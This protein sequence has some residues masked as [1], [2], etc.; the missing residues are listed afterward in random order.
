MRSTYS[1]FLFVAM[2]RGA[3]P[4]PEARQV[5]DPRAI[6]SRVNPSAGP[7]EIEDLYYTR[8][9][10]AASWSPDGKE[11]VFAT[12]LAGR[13]NLW[14]VAAGGG[15]PVQLMQSDD[16]QLHPVWSPDG[17]WIL[18]QQDFGGGEYFDLFL[19][20]SS[21]G[22]AI[23]LTNSPD[24]SETG[25]LWSPDG[26]SIAFFSK[27]RKGSSTDI[28][29]MDVV[30]RK[31]SQLTHEN[32][33]E[34]SWSVAAW[35]ADGRSVIANRR[36]V[37]ATDC[38]VYRVDFAS[39]Q[40]DELTPHSGQSVIAA[41]AVSPDG[42]TVLVSSS[43]KGGVSK[44]ALLNVAAKKLDWV[45]D[46]KWP[47]FPGSFSPL[48]DRFTYAVNEDGRTDLYI[49][50]R[51]TLKASHIDFLHGVSTF[52]GVTGTFSPSGQQLL[53]SHTESARP[54]DL[55]VHGIK[56][57][58]SRQLTVSALGS[59]DPSR[60]P[61]AQLIHYRSF[62][63]TLISAFLWVPHNLKR[64]GAAPAVL[65]PHGGPAGQVRDTFNQTA[66]ALA[67]RGYICIAPNV[68]GSSGYGE[69]FEHMNHKDL[70]GGDLQDEVY[71][72]RFVIDTGYA[73]PARI[74][75]AG[76]SYGGYMTLMAVAKTPDLWA[77]GVDSYGI[78]SW[79]TM[80]QHS[81]PALQAYQRSLL[82][83]PVADRKVYEDDSPITFM[84]NVKA[85]L[86]VLHGD[87]DI[88]VPKEEAQQVVD[89]LEKQHNVVAAHYYPA[90]GHGFAKRENQIDALRRTVEWFDRYLKNK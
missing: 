88:R 67:T 45:T 66:A 29:V 43:E 89:L 21:G 36:N 65:L 76:G 71:A 57:G 2:L 34:Y 10:G 46:L 80:M 82:G 12:N 61:A 4:S 90:E 35:S 25:A 77:A 41:S 78:I 85:P 8:T 64:D 13:M 87:N 81:D 24:L 30:S 23:N 14:K 40:A 72:R 52:E 63:G 48:G 11:V 42:K 26:R 79:F 6:T 15:F 16:R 19:V 20:P 28:A 53:I 83:D 50:D 68:R 31:V 74:G 60:I 33:A 59:L 47:A 84:R 62:D 38:S 44:I 58:S 1:L 69:A 55:W 56:D 7:V 37:G 73:D 70:G 32:A 54:N 22:K 39:G 17:K 9:T 49:V 27:T 3:A 75:I 5:T 51:A 86:L 18:Y